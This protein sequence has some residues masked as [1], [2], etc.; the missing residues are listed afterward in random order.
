[1]NRLE[2]LAERNL[3]KF[4]KGKYTVLHLRDESKCQYMLGD[5][6]MESSFAEKVLG[7]FGHQAIHDWEYASMAKKVNSIL[8]FMRQSSISRLSDVILYLTSVLVMLYVE[9]M[10]STGFPRVRETWTHKSMSSKGQ[11]KL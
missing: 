2:K 10:S 8:G 1:M 5:Y 4:G 9:C 11:Q 7:S 6:W 3:L